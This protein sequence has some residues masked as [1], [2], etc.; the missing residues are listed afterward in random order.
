MSLFFC[1]FVCAR[2]VNG[3]TRLG[4]SK[5]WAKMGL[6]AKGV[7]IEGLPSSAAAVVAQAG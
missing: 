6:G 1:C 3:G 7:A 4:G 5:I 2:N